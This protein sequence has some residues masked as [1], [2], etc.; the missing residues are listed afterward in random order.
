MAGCEASSPAPLG[1]VAA[2]QQ[3]TGFCAEDVG[4]NPK[5]AATADAPKRQFSEGRR[6][7]RG[8]LPSAIGLRGEGAGSSTGATKKQLL[9]IKK[10]RFIT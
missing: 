7:E 10:Y 6:R 1:E 3:P 4:W 9:P 2:E 5:Q 8:V